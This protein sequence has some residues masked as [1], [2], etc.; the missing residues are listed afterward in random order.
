VSAQ[1]IANALKASV[2]VEHVLKIN[3]N[4]FA[5]LLY[6]HVR[7]IV[8][9]K[10]AKKMHVHALLLNVVVQNSV[11]VLKVNANVVNVLKIKQ[12][13]FALLLFVHVK[14][15]VLVNIVRKLHVLVP[16][17]HALVQ[18]LANVL[19]VS[20]S[21]VHVLKISLNVFVQLLLAHVRA[22]VHVNIVRNPL[23]HA[24]L[25][26]VVVQRSVNVLK[27]NA[28]AVNV[29]KINPNVF[30]LLLFVH[31]K[32]IVLVNIVRKLHVHIVESNNIL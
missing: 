14:V 29:L 25:Q 22:I 9:V 11:N 18:K 19:K 28:N 1:R 23:V 30:A 20:V 15:I 12:S 17:L 5:L 24:H 31:V 8:L 4:V 10:N 3:P 13:V 6:A 7:V 21:V 16:L 2:S 26:N 27:V 32:A